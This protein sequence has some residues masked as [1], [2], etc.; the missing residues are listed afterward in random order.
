M[1]RKILFDIAI[2][3]APWFFPP[4]LVRAAKKR[5]ME[6]ALRRQGMPVSAARRMAADFYKE[7]L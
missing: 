7:Y 6:R 1:N 5:R 2:V 3:G 4:A